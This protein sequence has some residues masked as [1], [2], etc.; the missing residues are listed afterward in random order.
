M[1]AKKRTIKHDARANF[2]FPMKPIAFVTFSLQSL[3]SLL[4]L[5]ND[6]D[7]VDDDNDDVNNDDD[8]DGDDFGDDIFSEDNVYQIVTVKHS[9]PTDIK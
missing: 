5:P 1:T 9:K 2:F 7:D 6:D 8:N 4:K 3:A